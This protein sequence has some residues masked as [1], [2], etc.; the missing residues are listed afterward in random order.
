MGLA[1]ELMGKVP[2]GLAQ[3]PKVATMDAGKRND[4][5]NGWMRKNIQDELTAARGAMVSDPGKTEFY[6]PPAVTNRVVNGIVDSSRFVSIK[7]IATAVD[8]SEVQ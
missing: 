5:A 8:A 1:K 6:S 2:N 7:L 4:Y 3:L